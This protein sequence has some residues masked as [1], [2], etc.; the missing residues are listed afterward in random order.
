MEVDSYPKASPR[1]ATVIGSNDKFMMFRQFRYVQARLLLHKQDKL[2][3]LS[4]RLNTMDR[5][6]EI[7]SHG[8]SGCEENG[9]GREEA[10]EKLLRTLE[11]TFCQYGKVKYV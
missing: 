10:S 1:L 2:H 5:C 7:E 4:Q 9:N 6:E 11:A 8:T 3:K